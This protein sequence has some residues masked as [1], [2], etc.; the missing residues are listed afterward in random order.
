MDTA[1]D[2]PTIWNKLA[3]ALFLRD[4]PTA[5]YRLSERASFSFGR[6]QS[7][8]G[9][10]EMSQPV[11]GERGHIVVLQLKPIP[12]IEQFFGKKKV[13][14]G[15]YPIGGVSAIDLREEP[16]VL[17]P[18]PFDALVLYV[19]QAALD[20]AAYAH[21]APRVQQL[22][23]P[24]GGFDSVVHHLAQPLL[25][26]LERP[27]H[28]SKIFLDHVLQALNSHFV[29]S[30]GGVKTS[31]PHFRGGLSS[32]QMRRATEL[33]EANLDGDVALQKIAEECQLSVSH[34]ARAFKQTFRT[35][36]YRWLIERRVDKARDLMTN[37]RLA[38]ADIAIQC[39]FADQSA[40]NRSFKR[41]H[42]ITPGTWRR[43]TRAAA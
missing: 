35:P 21:R 42:G 5:E 25:S 38:L 43:G 18:N 22:V 14:S 30:Y 40:L 28:A 6:I 37:S 36:P 27:L 15:F 31:T 10:P 1:T 26:S 11:F 4:S 41:I 33:L 16:A 17:L 24:Q 19:T 29:C 7:A 13:S 34:F 23:W 2:V 8:A 39:G 20:E 12:F 9:L 32:M 3:D